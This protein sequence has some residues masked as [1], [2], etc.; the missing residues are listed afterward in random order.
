MSKDWTRLFFLSGK[1]QRMK[2]RL[3]IFLGNVSPWGIIGM[4]LILAVI[5]LVLAVTNYNREKKYMEQVLREKGGALIRALEAGARTGMMGM[6]GERPDLQV[7]LHETASQP[8][9]LYIA[10]VDSS[11]AILVHNDAAKIGQT[12]IEPDVL[13]SMHPS[14][15]VQWRTADRMATTKAFEVYKLFQPI[16][17][18]DNNL[19]NSGSMNNHMRQMMHG[20]SKSMM[21]MNP[22]ERWQSGW[23]RGMNQNGSLAQGKSSVIL[24]G[25]DIAPY[26]EAISE[27]I[28]LSL[29]MSG[30]LL[31][32]GLGGV[33]SLFWMQSHLRSRK[34]L[35]DTKALTSEIVANI[36]EGI[37]VYGQ[38][39]KIIYI[40][41][42]ALQMLG[43]AGPA[44][45]AVQLAADL[46]PPALWQL[47]ARV[48][49]EQ[50]IVEAEIELDVEDSRKLPVAVVATDI[51]TAEG[52][53]VGQM[54]LLRDLSQIKQLQEEIH[55][56][57]RMAAIGH[58]AAGV[59]HEVRNPLSSI[60]GY[61]TYFG[62][63]FPDNSDN[64]KAAE[65]M[66]S[67]VDRLNRVISELLEM[68][69][70]ADIRK[71]DTE[72]STLLESSLRLVKQEA[73]SS[74]VRISIASDSDVG[75]IPVDPDRLTQALINLYINAIQ[76]MPDGGELRVFASRRGSNL[77]LRI[78]DTGTGLPGDAQSR[79]FNPYFTTK[80]TG[81]GLGLAIVSKIVEAHKG[82][83]EVESTGSD[84]TTFCL[85]IPAQADRGSKS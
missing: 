56:A 12:L 55:K 19:H 49:P 57:D 34:L 22:N 51:L 53:V 41:I 37:I 54:F 13:A 73:E 6:M 72:I 5:V 27:D 36:P 32:L 50:R 33:V 74:R 16:L 40:N 39:G 30:I 78:S 62:S 21:G 67:E 46:L 11:G 64:K 65:V 77:L 75:S 84:G 42:I 59:A 80:Q 66:T 45:S 23:G 43:V 60:K 68:A 9:I 24:I 83:I 4:S 10:I 69:R 79:I 71:R 35:Q 63:L 85:G 82:T 48:S 15:E 70:P 7:L 18:E 76:A 1:Q 47:H 3:K 44:V 29:T 25:M 26:K 61:A 58:L 38:D 17:P 8:D 52:T 31:L 81:T 14:A 20:R 28:S 2:N